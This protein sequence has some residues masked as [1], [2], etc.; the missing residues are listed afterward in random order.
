MTPRARVRVAESFRRGLETYHSAARTQAQIAR[1][2]VLM[3]RGNGAPAGFA[4]ALEF[5]CGTGHLTKA[6]VQSFD[7]DTLYLNDLLPEAADLAARSVAPLCPKVLTGPVESLDLPTGID[8]IASAS[9]VQWVLDWPKVLDRLCDALAPKGWLA[10]SGFGTNQYHELTVLSSGG[11]APNYM[12]AQDWPRILPQGMELLEIRQTPIVVTFDSA[13]EV[14]R[15]LRRTGVNG[16]AGDQWTREQL[17]R[18]ETAYHDRFEQDG[19][20]TLTYDPVMLIA[21][22]A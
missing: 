11:A 9:T 8:L 7:L 21:R 19:K 15:H 14:L 12:D 13:R 2:L 3:L 22:K 10:L 18:F 17:Q 20:V 6:L 1:D 16:R 4:K 5:G